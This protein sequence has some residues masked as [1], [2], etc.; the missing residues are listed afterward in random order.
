MKVAVAQLNNK[1]TTVDSAASSVLGRARVL[2]IV[3]EELK[4]VWADRKPAKEALDTAVT[5]A[6]ALMPGVR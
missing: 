6:R 4:D 2:S 1:P 5:R 3:D